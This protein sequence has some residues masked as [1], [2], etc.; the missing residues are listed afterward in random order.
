MIFVELYENQQNKAENLNLK[1]QKNK[2][3]IAKQN[4]KNNSKNK[5]QFHIN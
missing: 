4:E 2:N 1:I 5:E 3:Q